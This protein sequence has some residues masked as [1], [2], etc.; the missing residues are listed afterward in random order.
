MNSTIPPMAAKDLIHGQGPV[1]LLDVREHGQYG[2]GHLL[3]ASNCPYSVLE[4][5]APR[6]VPDQACPII[7]YD[8]NDGVAERAAQCLST[9]GYRSVYVIEGGVQAWQKSGL[10]LFRGVNVPSKV[11]GELVESASHTPT[12]TS[13]EFMRRK[14]G[15]EEMFLVDGR[16]TSEYVKMTIPDA[17][18]VPN[19]ELLYRFEAL[20]VQSHVPIV[21]HCAGRTRGLI[22]AQSLINAGVSNP[23]FAFE[24]GTQGWVLSGRD[25]LRG[26]VAD[27]LPEPS[28]AQSLGGSETAD[29]MAK[30]YYV[31]VLPASDLENWR[32]NGDRVAYLL[33]VRSREEFDRGHIPGSRHAP[34]VQLVQATDEWVAMRRARIA[35]V[36]DNC[37][38]AV[39]AAM[40]LRKL[41]HDAVVFRDAM[42]LAVAEDQDAERTE[43]ENGDDTIR[44][45]ETIS[46]DDL[47]R[48]DGK[49]LIIDVRSSQK[50][51]KGHIP[52]SVWAIRPRINR[53]VDRIV[54]RVVFV[55]DCPLKAALAAKELQQF[56]NVETRLLAGGLEAWHEAGNRIE[57]ASEEPTDAEC[58]DFLYFVH[59]RHSGNLDSSRQ[60]LAWETGLVAQL[61]D[62]D[63]SMFSVL[64]SEP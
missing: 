17:L 39:S 38:R 28:Q 37:V 44:H 52:A 23:V 54:D 15:G 13:D 55:A 10:G 46:V 60:Y 35:L 29:A 19:G 45:I 63:Q 22:G 31:P 58:I 51:K 26:A 24:N 25:L 53:I 30:K 57:V 21:I 40:W 5:R 48:S 42:S 47:M 12:L 64:R 32:K 49:D 33:D 41:G 56:R 43:E 7:V 16:P 61:D 20:G 8:D 4:M 34:V 36:D 27:K 18:S 3:F 1:A 59:D 11:L 2:E 14:E 9:M 6:L 62:A 50:F